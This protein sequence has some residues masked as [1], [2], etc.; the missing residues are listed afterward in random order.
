MYLYLKTSPIEN[1]SLLNKNSIDVLPPNQNSF[2]QE[3]AQQIASK[4][5]E[6]KIKNEDLRSKAQSDLQ[7]WYDERKKQMEN[8]RQTNRF[9]E[10]HLDTNTSKEN[11]KQ[12]CNWSKLINLVDFTDGKQYSKSKR[13][14]S[15]M[16]SCIFNAKRF[17]NNQNNI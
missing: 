14:L 9:E 5:E 13:D 6:E 11:I 1:G 2:D 10:D 8:R 16:K 3:R 15:R 7:T 12:S 17:N 4:D